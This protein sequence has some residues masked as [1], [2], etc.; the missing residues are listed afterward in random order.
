MPKKKANK[1]SKKIEVRLR[2]VPIHLVIR[3][4]L[5]KLDAAIAQYERKEI[6]QSAIDEAYDEFANAMRPLRV[7]RK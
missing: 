1:T 6:S 5:R 4:A 3:R 2:V 7:R